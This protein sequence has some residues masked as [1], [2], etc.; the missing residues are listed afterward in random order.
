L[1]DLISIISLKFLKRITIM[2][3]LQQLSTGLNKHIT[4]FPHNMDYH[5][6]YYRKYYINNSNYGKVYLKIHGDAKHIEFYVYTGKKNYNEALKYINLRRLTKIML[7]MGY[8]IT[9]IKSICDE[10][11]LYKL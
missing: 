5:K 3:T 1:V 9:D 2:A 8:S 4:S 11:K 10:L 7:G 6:S